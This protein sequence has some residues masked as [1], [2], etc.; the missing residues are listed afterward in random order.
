M[1]RDVYNALSIHFVNCHEG[2]FRNSTIR[3]T[4]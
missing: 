4:L 3:A 1:V 2:N